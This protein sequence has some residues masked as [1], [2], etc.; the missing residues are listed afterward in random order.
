MNNNNYH[1]E[2]N[3]LVRFIYI[4]VRVCVLLA[5]LGMPLGIFWNVAG[6][7]AAYRVPMM[8]V[9]SEKFLETFKGIYDKR[10]QSLPNAAPC[11]VKREVKEGKVSYTVMLRPGEYNSLMR[12]HVND[13]NYVDMIGISCG[14]DDAQSMQAATYAEACIDMILGVKVEDVD[15]LMR[16]GVVYCSVWGKYLRREMEILPNKALGD[17]IMVGLVCTDTGEKVY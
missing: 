2:N 1:D 12:V 3:I 5:L 8:N 11:E 14:K 4:G 17:I 9:A 6:A 7:E 10:M 13:D 15:V 16:D